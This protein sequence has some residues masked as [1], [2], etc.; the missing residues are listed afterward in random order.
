MRAVA[1]QRWGGNASWEA[2]RE[3]LLSER[4]VTLRALC[5]GFRVFDSSSGDRCRLALTQGTQCPAKEVV[6]QAQAFGPTVT[7]TTP[8]GSSRRDGN[9]P[10]FQLGVYRLWGRGAVLQGGV[11]ALHGAVS[12]P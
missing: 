5:A 3:A 11:Y 1:V 12:P 6:V 4:Q 9:Q 7:Y 10:A 8:P 2:A